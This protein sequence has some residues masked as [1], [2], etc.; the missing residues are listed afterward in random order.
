MIQSACPA[1]GRATLRSDSSAAGRLY[2]RAER[3]NTFCPLAFSPAGSPKSD[4]PSF[5]PEKLPGLFTRAFPILLHTLPEAER[6]AQ[7]FNNVG[8]VRQAV[9]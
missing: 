1:E 6:F 2:G 7:Q 5:S 8:M 9:K 3:L 4:K